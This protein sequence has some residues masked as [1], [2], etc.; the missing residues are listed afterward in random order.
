[1]IKYVKLNQTSFQ[2]V[3]FTNFF[4]A[5]NKNLL[6]QINFNIYFVNLI[7]K[8]NIIHWFFMKYKQVIWNVLIA[9]LY[10]MSHSFNIKAI[11]KILIKKVF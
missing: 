7:F 10:K 11:I 9:K 4:F 6:L 8:I 2:L 5:N 3:I 1:M